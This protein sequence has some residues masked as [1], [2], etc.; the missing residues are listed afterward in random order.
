LWNLRTEEVLLH[1]LIGAKRGLIRPSAGY[2][3]VRIAKESKHLARL[4]REDRQ[5]PPS[6]QNSWQWRLLDKGFLQLAAD[7]PR[8]PLAL[9]HSTM[10]A[11]PLTQALRFIDEE[12]PLRQLVSLIPSIVPT[13]FRRL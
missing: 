5:L 3:V 6:W 4:W 7:D 13:V 1:V 9:L 8:R 2:G 10:H 12:L 11:I